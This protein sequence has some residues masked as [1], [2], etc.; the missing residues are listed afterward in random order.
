M[1]AKTALA[2]LLIVG[3]VMQSEG[4][5]WGRRRYYVRR[6]R[7]YVRRRRYDNEMRSDEAAKRYY[8]RRRRWYRDAGDMEDVSYVMCVWKVHLEFV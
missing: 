4:F 6:R 8:A 2:L 7:Y 3:L 5:L 1:N